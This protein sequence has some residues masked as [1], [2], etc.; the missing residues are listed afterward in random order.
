[1]FQTYSHARL[2]ICSSGHG[3]YD[4][5]IKNLWALQ[6]SLKTW[7]FRIDK[8]YAQILIVVN[9]FGFLVIARCHAMPFW[10]NWRQCSFLSVSRTFLHQH[11][12]DWTAGKLQS[13]PGLRPRAC[14]ITDISSPQPT[15]PKIH[16]LIDSTHQPINSSIQPI[17]T[18]THRLIDSTHQRIE[19]STHQFNPLTHLL[20]DSTINSWI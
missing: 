6:D 16:Q 8:Q 13:S 15:K 18:W 10:Y 14:Q 5:A 20:I 12:R 1:M 3:E 19:P 9:I 17:H 7:D 4:C 11:I 2:G